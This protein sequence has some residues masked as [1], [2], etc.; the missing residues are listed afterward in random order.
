MRWERLP[1]NI[2]IGICMGMVPLL[3]YSYSAKNR[4]RMDEV[5]R[6][7]RLAGLGIGIISLQ[8]LSRMR[9]M[10]EYES[11]RAGPPGFRA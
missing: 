2:G 6:F 5:F 1:L 8:S 10:Q 7:G 11:R 9:S 4:E 3:A